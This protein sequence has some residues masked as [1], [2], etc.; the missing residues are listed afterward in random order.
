MNQLFPQKKI[1]AL[2][3]RAFFAHYLKG[4]RKNHHFMED[5][6]CASQRLL[7]KRGHPG[8]AV[9]G[10]VPQFWYALTENSP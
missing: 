6:C 2:Q 7:T 5:R 3:N 8:K 1:N 4:G 9:T 10:Q